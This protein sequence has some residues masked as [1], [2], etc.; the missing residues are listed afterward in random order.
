MTRWPTVLGV[1]LPGLALAGFGLLHPG[2]LDPST[3]RQWW[4]LHVWLIPVFPL[5][6]L[7]IGV[8][9]R[10]ERGAVAAAARVA[11]YGFA[12]FY[13]GLD[14]LAGIGA[15]LVTDVQQGGSPAVGRLFEVGDRLGDA[16]VWC[17][18]ASAVLTGVVLVRRD[19]PRA[20]AG[21]VVLA[22]ACFPFLEGH[23]FHPTGV[24]AMLG[25]ATGCALLAAA[26]PPV[27]E[28]TGPP[29]RPD[30]DPVSP[31]VART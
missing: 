8:L 13:T 12:T 30:P 23:I 1:A 20:L 14:V 27:L 10:G 16:G 21:A 28:R 5:I 17:L 11:A 25:I 29:L 4:Q 9:L 26:R 31:P 24:L 3:A 7:A 15:G 18:L 6:S 2:H 19:G 22:G